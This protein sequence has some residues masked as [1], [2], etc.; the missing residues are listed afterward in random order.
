MSHLRFFGAWVVGIASIA[1]GGYHLLSSPQ[2]DP[3]SHAIQKHEIFDDQDPSGPFPREYRRYYCRQ[4]Y[5]E[6][7]PRWIHIRRDIPPACRE[8]NRSTLRGWSRTRRD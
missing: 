8:W 7:R 2:N 4:W 6:N 1:M 3:I 5:R